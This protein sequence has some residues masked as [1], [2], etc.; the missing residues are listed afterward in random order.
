T[1][2]HAASGAGVSRSHTDV[3]TP[4]VPSEPTSSAVRS[5]P[6]TSLRNGPPRRTSSPG[7]TT[8]SSPVTHAP[9][10]PYL[11]ACGPPAFVATFPPICDCSAAPGSGAKSRPPPRAVCR[12]AAVVTPA[13]T[14]IRHSRG[15]KERT[16]VSRSSATTTPPSTGTAPAAYPVPPPRGTTGTPC[17]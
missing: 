6:A 7:A 9:V 11:N 17:P 12:T 10:T 14:S 4:S 13:S 2:G 1:T 5:Y 3:I 15:S 16:R 8:T